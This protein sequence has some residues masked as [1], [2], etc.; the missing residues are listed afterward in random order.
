MSA[1]LERHRFNVEQ[2]YRMAETGILAADARVELIEGEI[3]DRAP[4]GVLDSA[5]AGR[6]SA[7]LI[8]RLSDDAHVR[9]QSPVRLSSF[10]EPLPDLAILRHRS[11]YYAAAHPG[12]DDVLWLIEV[13][14]SSLAF[15][16]GAKL[17]LYAR[18]GIAE[19]WIV[20]LPERRLE[21]YA[22]PGESGYARQ[23]LVSSGESF[24]AEAMPARQWTLEELLG[25]AA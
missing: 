6:L 4:P 18:H 19:V 5:L 22:G 23:R 7:K 10:S 15:D 20:N 2:Y 9:C 17:A 21:L 11:D 16:R 24:A 8:L 25:W 12:P 3:V 1:V 13:A 14:E